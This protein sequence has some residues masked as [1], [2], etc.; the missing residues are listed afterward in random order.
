[1][2]TPLILILT[3]TLLTTNQIKSQ[4]SPSIFMNLGAGGSDMGP[5]IGGSMSCMYKMH[6]FTYRVTSSA[7]IV[8][9][10]SFI[11][12]DIYKTNS[13]T[14]IAFMYG[15][16]LKFKTGYLSASAGIGMLQYNGYFKVAPGIWD[17]IETKRL[18]RE[19]GV[20]VELQWMWMGKKGGGAGIK[21]FGMFTESY[22][23]TGVLFSIQF[24]IY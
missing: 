6:L 9:R 17:H 21:G 18:N 22:S 14:D 19:F 16:V 3:I 12:P 11:L 20:P 13:K 7:T 10:P 8:N 4:E 15:R 24:R 1:M 2:K 23:H 5:A